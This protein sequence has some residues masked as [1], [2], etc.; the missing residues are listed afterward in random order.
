MITRTTR[1]FLLY[2]TR[3]D[4]KNHFLDTLKI[5]IELELLEIFT[6]TT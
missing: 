2:D 5:L 3:K 6:L 1:F 4:F